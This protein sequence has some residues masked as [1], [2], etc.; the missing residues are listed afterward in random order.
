MYNGQPDENNPDT[1]SP[2]GS[3]K[4][5]VVKIKS[6]SVSTQSCLDT[7]DT[8]FPLQ[9]SDVKSGYC[10]ID[11]Y[12]YADGESAPYAGSECR[13]CDAAVNAVEWS[14]PDMSSHCFI[15]DSCVAHGT[16]EQVSSGYSTVD[17]PCSMC[18]ATSDTA[19]FSAV[20]GCLLPSAFESGFYT[21]N[22]SMLMNMATYMDEKTTMETSIA[23]K[24]AEIV[25]LTDEK[26]ALATD[27]AGLETDKAVLEATTDADQATITSLE[28]SIATKSAEIVTLT[29]EKSTCQAETAAYQATN[30]AAQATILSLEADECVNG[31]SKGIAMALISVLCILFLLVVLILVLMVSR[32]VPA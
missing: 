13:K 27:N 31:M 18:D 7:C 19:A 6:D 12:C 17:D 4:A 22:G 16:H 24:S 10:Y 1:S 15:D 2:V 26:S 28:T 5:F 14:D 25:T 3:S 11:R 23:T 9:A 20:A 8:A 21:T 32:C 29:D 30:D